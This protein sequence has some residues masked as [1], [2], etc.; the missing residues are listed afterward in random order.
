MSPHSATSLPIN[1]YSPREH[2]E[3][4][5][6]GACPLPPLHR[7]S[8]VS[9]RVTVFFSVLFLS[10]S[11]S[12]LLFHCSAVSSTFRLTWFLTV[13]AL[14]GAQGTVSVGLCSSY[15][16]G[17]GKSSPGVVPL[18]EL[19]RGLGLGVVEGGRGAAD[20]HGGPTV[21]SQRILQDPGHLTVP[22]WHIGLTEDK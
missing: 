17:F 8:S 4:R 15:N 10:F 2:M 5:Y 18:P 20:H 12:H 1:S 3:R 14:I 22:V 16:G 13:F 9:S 19:Q 6:W 7:L 11:F 21:S